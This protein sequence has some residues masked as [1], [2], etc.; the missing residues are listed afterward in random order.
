MVDTSS[1]SARLEHLDELVTELDAIRDGGRDGYMAQWRTRLAAE[2]ALQ[3]AIQ[4]CIDVGA[5]MVS[6]LGLKAPADYRGVFESLCP[7]GLDARLAERLAAAA[8]MRNILVHGYLDVD[9]EAVWAAL[10]RLGDLRDFAAAMQRIG[11]SGRAAP[12]K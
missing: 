4:T 5:H 7:A 6:E 1:V 12:E 8:G 9:D 2:H 10:D 3:L 11:E